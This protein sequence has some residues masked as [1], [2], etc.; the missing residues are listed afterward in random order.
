VD[1]YLLMTR[2]LHITPQP[3]DG[4]AATVKAMLRPATR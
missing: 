1:V 4:D 2:L 3:N